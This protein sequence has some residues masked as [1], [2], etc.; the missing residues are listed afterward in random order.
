MRVVVTHICDGSHW[1]IA[2]VHRERF[3]AFMM[4]KKKMKDSLLTIIHKTIL[5]NYAITVSVGLPAN[6]IAPV[7]QSLIPHIV[8]KR[9]TGVIVA[10]EKDC[11]LHVACARDT[12]R[13]TRRT[14]SFVHSSPS[15]HHCVCFVFFFLLLLLLIFL[16]V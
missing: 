13:H 5:L 3:D 6:G 10:I 15:F 8:D 9:Q 4:Q 14:V 2:N 11:S 12:D 16:C 1:A 7:I